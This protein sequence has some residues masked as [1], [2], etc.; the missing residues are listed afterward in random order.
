MR[1]LNSD[2]SNYSNYNL[3]QLDLWE[4]K[5]WK[6]SPSLQQNKTADTILD[7]LAI[8]ID[9]QIIEIRTTKD[10]LK[11]FILEIIDRYQQLCDTPKIH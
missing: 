9:D 5:K 10:N 4:V 1:E 11:Q 6:E 7:L 8:D 2:S 3:Y